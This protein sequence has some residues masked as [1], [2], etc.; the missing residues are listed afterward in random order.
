MYKY[1]RVDFNTHSVI[2]WEQGVNRICDP[3]FLESVHG[4]EEMK[5]PLKQ[6]WNFYTEIDVEGNV[7]K[8]SSIDKSLI[9]DPEGYPKF[10]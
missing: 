2:D 6:I 3:L 1:A 10:R 7:C 9:Q 8:V 5:K 4:I